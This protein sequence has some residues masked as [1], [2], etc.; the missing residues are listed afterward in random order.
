MS[1]QQ[2]YLLTRLN[3]SFRAYKLSSPSRAFP[4]RKHC[5]ACVHVVP[6][7][8]ASSEECNVS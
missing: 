8:I 2:S 4:L 5:T 7:S 6:Q 3:A 1:T